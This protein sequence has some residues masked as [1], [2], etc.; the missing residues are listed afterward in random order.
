[1]D[2]PCRRE[3]PRRAAGPS[4]GGAGAGALWLPPPARLVASRARRAVART[5]ERHCGHEARA[6]PCSARLRRATPARPLVP[7]RADP[8]PP[9]PGMRVLFN[10][11]DAGV[12]GGQQVA[13]DIA[14][15]LVR[16]GHSVG[17][18]VPATG[19]ATSRFA[20]L[21]ASTHTAHLVSLRRPG[22]IAGA[23]IAR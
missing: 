10:L 5:A 22:V 11:L 3:A 4:A 9:S 2:D 17:V 7:A 19:P 6:A 8:Q 20:E 16:R 14:S 1:M 23:R 12:G 13:F 15:E 18:V 21:G